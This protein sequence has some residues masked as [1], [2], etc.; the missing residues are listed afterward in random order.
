[1]VQL[2]QQDQAVTKRAIARDCE[3]CGKRFKPKHAKARFH[4][5][6]C[7]KSYSRQ[8]GPKVGFLSQTPT[9]TAGVRIRSKSGSEI[10]GLQF[11]KGGRKVFGLSASPDG[12]LS[13]RFI[14]GTPPL[15]ERECRL[16]GMTPLADG[17]YAVRRPP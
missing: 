11:G 8:K 6:A 5:E 12:R 1:V 2:S 14:P 17:T 15:T 4:S 3:G 16:F 10:N 7:R 13:Y 9:T